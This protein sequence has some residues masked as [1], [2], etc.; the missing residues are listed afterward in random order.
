MGGGAQCPFL[1]V[2]EPK[3]TGA[4]SARAR[5]RGQNPLVNN[6]RVQ[7]GRPSSSI[8]LTCKSFWK[9]CALFPNYFHGFEIS[10]K[11]CIIFV[12]V[13]CKQENSFWDH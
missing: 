4:R 3:R 9:L 8:L 2:N 10:V 1:R 7:N 11:F 6:I 13:I 12:I 5:T